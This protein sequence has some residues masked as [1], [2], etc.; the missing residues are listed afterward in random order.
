MYDEIADKCLGVRVMKSEWEL[1]LTKVGKTALTVEERMDPSAW[2][3]R[4]EV[5]QELPNLSRIAVMMLNVPANVLQSDRLVGMGAYLFT[6]RRARVTTEHFRAHIA[7]Y[8]NMKS[9]N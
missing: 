8:A 5:Q 4:Q 2:W 9:N 3:K 6:N 1:Y 7:A